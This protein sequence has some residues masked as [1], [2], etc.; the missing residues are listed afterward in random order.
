MQA[1]SGQA[2]DRHLLGLKLLAAEAGMETPEVF[3]DVAF[4]RSL[5]FCL[6]TSQVSVVW[7]IG[8]VNTVV[9]SQVP[10]SNYDV[11]LTFGAVV[12]DGYGV[13]YNPQ[14]SKLLMAVSS[15]KSCP[16]TDSAVFSSKLKESMR[17]MRDMLVATN[18]LK[19]KI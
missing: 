14:E 1:V 12:P 9:P 18:P 16:Q 15:F 3:K 2:V 7:L 17:D 11:F 10:C 4:G 8:K 19:A 5:H 13:C 6:S